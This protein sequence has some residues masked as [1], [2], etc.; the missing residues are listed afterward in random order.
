MKEKLLQSINQLNKPNGLKQDAQESLL[1]EKS[2]Q[3]ANLLKISPKQVHIQRGSDGIN[4][5]IELQIDDAPLKEQFS[6]YQSSFLARVETEKTE[7][8]KIKLAFEENKNAL[9]ELSNIELIESLPI[10]KRAEFEKLFSLKKLLGEDWNLNIE[11]D[12]LPESI[13]KQLKQIDGLQ[14]ADWT[15]QAIDLSQLKI[16]LGKEPDEHFMGMIEK[17]STL[18]ND[19][20]KIRGRVKD[21]QEQV[22]IQQ[23]EINN[24]ENNIQVAQLRRQHSDCGYSESG[25]LLA[26]IFFYQSK[27]R[28]LQSRLEQPMRTL[29]D[30]QEEETKGQKILA[31]HNQ[32]LD[33]KRKDFTFNHLAQVKQELST[34]LQNTCKQRVNELENELQEMEPAIEN[35]EKIEL[36]K[37]RYQ[38]RRFFKTSE[39]L[40]YEAYLASEEALIPKKN[41][42]PLTNPDEFELNGLDNEQNKQS[43]SFAN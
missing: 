2:K 23:Q 21:A 28:Y 5:F 29:I 10:T 8:K 42:N 30:V 11:R 4:S 33:E 37:S 38:T 18:M 41:E 25:K 6:G 16:L 3:F 22:R 40:N 34:Y 1:Y 7:I 32:F 39:L 43:I 14:N 17:Q 35:L 15:S 31:E 9:L 36:K 24:I 20:E 27:I 19:F 12:D 26:Q 13:M